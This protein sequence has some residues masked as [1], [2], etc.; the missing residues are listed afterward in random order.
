MTLRRL[1]NTPL[2][3]RRDIPDMAPDIVD[4]SSVFN[5]GAIQKDGL[6]VLLLRVQTRGR[7][8]FTV[9]AVSD[10]GLQFQVA[11]QPTVFDWNSQRPQPEIF[12]IYDARITQSKMRFWLSPQ[13][14]PIQV[15]SWPCG[16][17]RG[18]WKP[19]F[20]G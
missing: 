19:D 7:R 18:N 10:S 13:W 1:G 20:W 11:P 3:T 9:P 15:A 12:H 14:T 4:P 8:T 2:L 17:R 5:P 16:E 6:T